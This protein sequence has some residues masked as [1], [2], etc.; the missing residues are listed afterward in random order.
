MV[1]EK[2]KMMDEKNR[3]KNGE[4]KIRKNPANI[5]STSP[6]DVESRRDFIST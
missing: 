1:K 4:I 5:F 3:E 6:V 2:G